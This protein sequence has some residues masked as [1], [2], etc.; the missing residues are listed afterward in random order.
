[1]REVGLV[2]IDRVDDIRVGAAFRAVRLRRHWR[3]Q[4]LAIRAGVSAAFVSLV[5]RGHL[6]R[7]SLAT[8]RRLAA[9]LDIRIDVVPRWR[10]GEL[11]RLVNA[12]HSALH[13][14]VAAHLLGVGGWLI[15]PE[16]TFAV[17]GER[18]AIDILAYHEASRCLLVIELKSAVIDVNELLGTLDRKRRLAARI[19]A[20]R[21]WQADTVSCL[22]VVQD[23]RT[24]RR[25][26]AAHRTVLRT[27]LPDGG[28]NG[29]GVAAGSS[30]HTRWP[31]VVAGSYRGW[32]RSPPCP[33]CSRPRAD[34]SRSASVRRSSSVRPRACRAALRGR[35]LPGVMFG[36][37]TGADLAER[38]PGCGLA[39]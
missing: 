38:Y 36:R 9:A 17:G 18:G 39:K 11:D 26:V 7:A 16:V 32:S 21:G 2:I 31:C 34:P 4:D 23:T 29:A 24:N 37:L 10:G 28:T 6:E 3:Q 22:L 19:A 8:L 27:A 15:A 30:W 35:F 14:S 25:R 33:A 5:E 12:R 1:M 20:E 13:E